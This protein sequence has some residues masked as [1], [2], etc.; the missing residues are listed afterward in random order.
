[1]NFNGKAA[2]GK[3]VAMLLALTPIWAA[4]HYVSLDGL[5]N[6]PYTNW[7]D[8]AT[9][10]IDAVTIAADGETIWITNGVF[11]ITNTLNLNGRKTLRSVNGYAGTII[12]GMYN[13]STGNYVCMTATSVCDGITISNGY[14]YSYISDDARGGGGVL[15]SS[16]CWLVNSKITRC[17]GRYN[18]CGGG[19]RITGAGVMTNCIV[20]SNDVSGAY[21]GGLCLEGNALVQDCLITD[22]QNVNYGGGIYFGGGFGTGAILRNCIVSNNTAA[23]FGAGQRADGGGIYMNGLGTVYN[24]LIINNVA[25]AWGCGGG[26]FAKNINNYAGKIVNCTIAGNYSTNCGG[27]FLDGTNNTASIVNC[28]IYSNFTNSAYTAPSDVTFTNSLNTNA[29]LNCCLTNELPSDRNCIVL[30]PQFI[31][32]SSGNYRLRM[33]SPCVNA[34]TNQSWMTNAVDLDGNSRILNGIVDLGAYERYIW[35][36]TVYHFQ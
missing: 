2:I 11:N 15:V 23:K 22:N 34:G 25:G 24:C 33:T 1:M 30:S 36:G 6:P 8:A 10:V 14:N 19:V 35:Q 32:F 4:E 5:N 17:H 12:N 27:L 16:A 3:I 29:F 28:I 31:G 13:G 7:A 26:V 21:G 20:H 9:N 18:S